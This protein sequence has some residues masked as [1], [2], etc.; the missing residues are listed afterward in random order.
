MIILNQ[1]I[2]MTLMTPGVGVPVDGDLDPLDAVAS[3]G[4]QAPLDGWTAVAVGGK[5]LTAG[6]EDVLRHPR[7]RPR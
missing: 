7:R 4:R 1:D 2:A 3:P 5:T 6:R